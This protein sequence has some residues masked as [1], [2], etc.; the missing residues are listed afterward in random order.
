MLSI[1][2]ESPSRHRLLY[3][4]F[5]IV[6]IAIS[7]PARLTDWYPLFFVIYIADGLWALMIYFLTAA[8]F[9]TLSPLKLFILC[10]CGT[11]LVEFS[12]LYQE[13]WINSVRHWPLVGLIL[14]YGF[15]YEDLI[16]YT[17]GIS[18]GLLVDLLILRQRSHHG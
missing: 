9:P 7:L 17:I 4:L 12:Q 6:L 5:V 15:R 18:V 2:Q 8:L 11:W 13:D 1:L 3:L 14:G 16:A 10:F